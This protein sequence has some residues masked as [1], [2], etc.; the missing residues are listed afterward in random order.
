MALSENCI[1]LVEEQGTEPTRLAHKIHQVSSRKN[2]PFLPISS[3]LLDQ[4]S[5]EEFMG[6]V[7]IIGLL[8]HIQGG[9]IVLQNVG[10]NCQ[11][12]NSWDEYGSLGCS[13]IFREEP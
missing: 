2:G 4:L 9:T 13:N 8:E 5:E 7:R 3:H 12:K 6:R 10:A 1:L 11:R